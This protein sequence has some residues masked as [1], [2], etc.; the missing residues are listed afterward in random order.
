MTLDET[1]SR[2][3]NQWKQEF[4]IND[5]W[6]WAYS[7]FFRPSASSLATHQPIPLNCI[8]ITQ[9][10]RLLHPHSSCGI[11]VGDAVVMSCSIPS[12]VTA[13]AAPSTIYRHTLVPRERRTKGSYFKK[14]TSTVTASSS[15]LNGQPTLPP[16]LS[17]HPAS[18]SPSPEE[19]EGILFRAFGVIVGVPP[20]ALGTWG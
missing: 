6:Q 1:A 2:T 18:R 5:M 13:L 15:S 16:S 19:A 4:I 17:S 14:N 9:K 11:P 12:L 8:A 10:R 7:Y 3:T 20:G